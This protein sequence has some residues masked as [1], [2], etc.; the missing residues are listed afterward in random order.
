[1]KKGSSSTIFLLIALVGLSAWYFLY[2][3]HFKLDKSKLEEKAKLLVP[4]SKEDIQ[5][6]EIFHSKSET[7]KLQ[8]SGQDWHLVSPVNDLADSSTIASMLTALTSAQEERQIESNASDLAPYGLVDPLLKIKARKDANSEVEIWIGA[9]T[10]VG[11]GSYAKLAQ[12][13]PIYKINRSLPSAFEKSVFEIRNKK[14]VMIPKE[15]VKEVEIQNTSGSF[16]LNKEENGKW[17]LAREGMPTDS[18]SW[19]RLLNSITELRA[20]AIVSETA[21]NLAKFGLARPAIQLWVTPLNKTKKQILVGLVA[22]KVFAKTEDK[23]FIYELDKTVVKELQK[24]ASDLRDKHL[25]A[26]D[27]F[28][29]SKIRFSGINN[30][31]IKKDGS[32]WVFSEPEKNERIDS[33]Q[34]EQWL[35]Q[36]QD[37]NVKRFMGPASKSVLKSPLLKLELYE[38]KDQKENLAAEL[39][40]SPNTLEVSGKS[41]YLPLAWIINLEDWKHLNLSKKDFLEKPASQTQEKPLE[42]NNPEK[43]S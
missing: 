14:L 5:E 15:E 22:E 35:T 42:N 6:L 17:F 8:R 12:R 16:L 7:I 40:L 37:V 26:F 13:S 43:K 18:A 23:P 32:G 21:T 38:S 33:S 27:R 28:S 29:V 10:E 9:Q 24:P 30:F 2:E 1:M 39:E 41:S 3:K 20:T 31:E 19:A 25:V 36:L 4:F 34:V 11:F